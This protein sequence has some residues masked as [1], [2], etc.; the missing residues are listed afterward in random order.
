MVQVS[1]R[2]V[3]G[4]YDEFEEK[5]SFGKKLLELQNQGY[6]GKELFCE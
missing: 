3:D 2:F 1:I 4:G 6:V 5:N